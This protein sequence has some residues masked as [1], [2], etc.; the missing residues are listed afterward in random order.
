MLIVALWQLSCA[1]KMCFISMHIQYQFIAF[2]F[3]IKQCYRKIFRKKFIATFNCTM[4]IISN[5]FRRY[6]SPVTFNGRCCFIGIKNIYL[7][8]WY[9]NGRIYFTYIKK[10]FMVL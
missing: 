4:L 5:C 10:I 3:I 8:N 9:K 1:Y 2:F 6:Y 7:N